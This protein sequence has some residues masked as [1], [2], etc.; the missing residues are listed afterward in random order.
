MDETHRVVRLMNTSLVEAGSRPLPS[1]IQANNFS[2]IV[3]NILTDSF[4]RLTPYKHNRAD[5]YP[6]LICTDLNPSVGLEVKSTIQVGKGGES[7][8][9]HSGWHLVVCFK[10]D[11]ISGDIL[12]LHAMFAELKGYQ[13]PDSDWAYVGS[14]VNKK[15]GS[16]RTE[17]Y[18]TTPAGKS[19]LR[20]GTVY[21]DT[22]H[23][24]TSRWRGGKPPVP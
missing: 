20:A 24:N 14:R 12:F 7:H 3:S 15:T 13:H 8:N 16:Q 2:G 22:A 6:D 19:K 9:G 21:M 4:D 17:T 5:R 11:S 10:L 1:Y 18:N 23:I